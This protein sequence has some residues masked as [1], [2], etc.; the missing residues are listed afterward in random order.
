MPTW[1]L[2]SRAQS[3]HVPQQ[4][5]AALQ[6]T[7]DPWKDT[8][9]LNGGQRPYKYRMNRLPD[10]DG[11]AAKL[12]ERCAGS[13]HERDFPIRET[14]FFPCLLSEHP[15]HLSR[16][17]SLSF[18]FRLQLNMFLSSPLIN[19]ASRSIRETALQLQCL[20]GHEIFEAPKINHHGLIKYVSLCLS[21]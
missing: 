20:N 8:A 1:S 13:F 21:H 17:L 3:P 18:F 6:R 9:Q 14:S 12:D 4:I 7:S 11:R 5:A 19:S 2:P 10:E 16:C 15:R